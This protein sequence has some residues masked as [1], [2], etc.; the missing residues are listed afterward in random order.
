MSKQPQVLFKEAVSS[1]VSD[2]IAQLKPQE[3]QVGA[4]DV[5]AD[6]NGKDNK[7]KVNSFIEAVTNKKPKNEKNPSQPSGGKQIKGGKAKGKGKGNGKNMWQD[8]GKSKSGHIG[9]GKGGQNICKT[10]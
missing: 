2:A 6:G 3:Q 10:M 9:K 7:A 1:I 4:M 8:K 5:D